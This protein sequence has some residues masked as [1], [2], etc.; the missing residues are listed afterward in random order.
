MLGTLTLACNTCNPSLKCSRIIGNKVQTRIGC[1]RGRWVSTVFDGFR[2]FSTVFDGFRRFSTVFDGFR[3][4]STVFDGFRRFSTF[5]DGF[6]RFSTVFDGFRRFSIVFDSFQLFSIVFNGLSL[7]EVN[8]QGVMW[9]VIGEVF[10]FFRLIL[11]F[12]YFHF[13]FVF[14]KPTTG[15]PGGI[16][17][18]PPYPNS[19]KD[20]HPELCVIGEVFYFFVYYYYYFIIFIFFCIPQ[21][22]YWFTWGYW[23]FASLPPT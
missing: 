19:V 4:F 3:R 14:Q 16:G 7:H 9:S 17:V 20:M 11:F 22:N 2:R 10:F 13:C 18:L 15:S 8:T 6:R 23:G 12:Y 1:V 5:F 21:T